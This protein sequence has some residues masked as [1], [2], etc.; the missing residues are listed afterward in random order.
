MCGVAGFWSAW[1]ED[2]PYA[3]ATAM[4]SRLRHRGPDDGGCW[5]YRDA[6]VAL[7][8]RR[9]SIVDLSPLGRQPMVSQSGR[10]VIVFNGEIYNHRA[11]RRELLADPR[12]ESRLR[13]QSDTEVMLAAIEAWGLQRAIDRFVGMFAFALWDNAD[14][15]LHLVRDRLGI[16]PLYW[17]WAGRVF[18]FASELNAICAHPAFRPEI[19]RDAL[20]LLMRY[21]CIP[22]PHSIYAGI[23][24][25][26]PGTIL[27]VRSPEPD[28]L[29][30]TTFWTAREA[31]ER[32]MAHGFAGS[33][34]EAVEELERLLQDAVR[35]RMLADV[36]V[37]AFLSGGIDSSTVAAMMQAQSGRPVKTFTIGSFD[38]EYDEAPAA[39]AVARHLGTDHCEMYVTAADAMAVVPELPAIYDEPFADASQ[40]PTFLVSR[41]ARQDVTV[42]LT[43]DGGDELFGGY[44]RHVWSARLWDVVRALPGGLRAGGARAIGALSPQ[45]WTQLYRTLEPVLPARWHQRAPGDKLHKMAGLLAASTPAQLHLWLTSRWRHP[46]ALVLGSSEPRATRAALVAS[47][48]DQTDAMLFLDLV[49]Y[50]P[51]DILTKVD[52]A[53]MAVSLEARVPMLDH[54]VVEFAWRLPLEMKIREGQGKWILRQ[55]LH[56]HVP[57]HL[58]ERPKSGFGVPVGAWLRGP[59]RPWAEDLLQAK[60]LR[61]DGMFDADLIRDKWSAHI[62]G[63]TDVFDALW[64]VLMFQAWN[65]KRGERAAA[66]VNGLASN[67]E[68]TP[69]CALS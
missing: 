50:L 56:R 32:G 7:A 65:G 55:V 58:V 62:S 24:K 40:L 6:G 3:T 45:Q 36:P 15:E 26:L 25:L 13:G 23:H 38:A 14:R 68:V 44:N 17:G 47:F 41:L 46:E 49:T 53:S 61:D 5:V 69:V 60:R 39:R 29:T 48:A 18:V 28:A 11:L 43:G 19:D 67:G 59:L 52:R 4:A 16:K 64:P 42:A 63:K 9:L 31:A 12:R 33:T 51:D 1:G 37:G 30:E 2:D 21:G 66:P 34:D 57:R 8:H 10:F 54:R 22:A 27:R 35:L 20:T